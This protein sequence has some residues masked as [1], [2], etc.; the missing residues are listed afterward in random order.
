MLFNS[1]NFLYFFPVALA[2]YFLTPQRLRWVTLVATSFFFYMCWN[3]KYIILLIISIVSNYFAGKLIE[4]AKT[5]SAKKVP[6][7]V[8]MLFNILLLCLFKYLNFFDDNIRAIFEF[9]HVPYPVPEPW[10]NKILLPVGISFYTFHTLGYTLDVFKGVSK[11]ERHL[12]K[13]ALFTAY[14]PLLLAGPIERSTTLLPQLNYF[15][16]FDYNR[17]REGFVRML[18]GYFKKVVIA[19]RLALYVE[20]LYNHY[21]LATGW[22]VWLGACLFVIQVYCDFSGYS[23]IAVGASRI[24]GINLLEN[25]KRPFFAKNLADFW[26]RWHISLSTW[27]TDYVF[28]YLGAYKASGSKVVFNVIFVLS[29]CGLW[30]GANWPMVLSF[31][32]IGIMMSI[33]YLWQYNVVKK[34]KPSNTYKLFDKLPDIFH[35]VVTFLMLVFGFMMFRAKDMSEAAVMYKNLFKL[36][37]ANYLYELIHYRG[38]ENFIIGIIALVILFAVEFW[39]GDKFI[40]EV[41]LKKGQKTRWAFYITFLLFV[42]WFGMFNSSLFVYFQ[43]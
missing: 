35:I 4:D 18:M 25:F 17:T 9:I 8:N 28:Y 7:V 15:K 41:I 20:E 22:T 33:R 26:T 23:D 27:L 12:G 13:F 16:D 10:F 29:I 34:I 42:V 40:E 6:L 11:A 43:F 3:P 5:H 21:D 24:M 1:L 36:G 37:E 19:D 32:T 14:W 30:H 39:T 38:L 2:L 31:T